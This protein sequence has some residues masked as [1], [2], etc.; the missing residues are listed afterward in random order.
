MGKKS[1]DCQLML[2][3]LRHA[4]QTLYIHT[5]NSLPEVYFNNLF[6]ELQLLF[7]YRTFLQ[8]YPQLQ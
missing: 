1:Q 8:L 7:N 6:A 3:L 2:L 4:L 5:Q